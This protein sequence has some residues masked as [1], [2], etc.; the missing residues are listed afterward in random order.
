MTTSI[1]E[2]DTDETDE[3]GRVRLPTY[4]DCHRC[5]IRI[6]GD[7]GDAEYCTA[8]VNI[9]KRKRRDLPQ[10]INTDLDINIYTRHSSRYDT[11]KTIQNLR[12]AKVPYTTA[13]MYD[14]GLVLAWLHE[15]TGGV[16]RSV[17]TVSRPGELLDW[18]EGDR[19]DKVAEWI[20]KAT[21][22][23]ALAA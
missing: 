6:P 23:L 7:N 21:Q 16:P 14:D 22:D 13:N 1:Y 17:V 11:G 15:L 5:G 2:P 3:N 8:C 9:L 10:S 20:S 12:A 19:P 18:W 4:R